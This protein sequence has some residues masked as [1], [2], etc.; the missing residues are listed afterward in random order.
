M[1]RRCG[2]WYAS[3]T[4]ECAPERAHGHRGAGIDWGSQTLA[5]VAIDFGETLQVEKPATSRKPWASCALDSGRWLRLGSDR[6]PRAGGPVA[7]TRNQPLLL[8]RSWPVSGEQALAVFGERF[9][10]AAL[11]ERIAS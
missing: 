4:I 2:C 6:G 3:V 1:V 9:R 7:L 5:P 11:H 10:V 8:A